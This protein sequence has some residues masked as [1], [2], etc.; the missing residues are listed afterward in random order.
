[1][2][3][4]EGVRIARE[5]DQPAMAAVG[6]GV[7]SLVAA[8]RGE[9][10]VLREH[11]EQ[12]TQSVSGGLA[13]ALVTWALGIDALAD[14]RPDAAHTHLRRLYD[15]DD[16]ASHPEVAR[17]A[18]ADLVEAGVGAG[19]ADDLE[20]LTAEAERLAAVAGG[21]RS[22]MVARRA[23]AVLD[24]G[25]TPDAFEAVLAVDGAPLWPFELARARLSQGTWLRR[26]RRIIAAR[27]PLRAAAEAFEALGARPW[28]E[29]ARTELRAAGEASVVRTKVA[30]DELTPQQRQVAQ[31]AA[32]G[33][34]NR[35]IGAQLYLSPRTVSFH[36][37]NIFPKL[38]VTTRSQLAAAVR[39]DILEQST[40]AQ[41][42]RSWQSG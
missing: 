40:A 41:S 42:E 29:R 20:R 39:A 37:Y 32:R 2:H 7:Q 6:V 13:R 23:R 27:D 38:G 4:T 17:W 36:L 9:H 24:D 25:P 3:A 10:D 33:L 19:I 11:A 35:E 30:G 14:G 28:E 12:A 22:V 15:A 1:M 16:P 8:L 34:S 21:T 31:L 5:V 26:H 18:I